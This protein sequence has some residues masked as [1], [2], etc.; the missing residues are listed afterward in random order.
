MSNV[1]NNR[2]LKTSFIYFVYIVIIAL[3]TDGVTRVVKCY[4]KV[5]PVSPNLPLP[6]AEAPFVLVKSREAASE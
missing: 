4:T 5:V 3:K 1:D 6:G 2:I